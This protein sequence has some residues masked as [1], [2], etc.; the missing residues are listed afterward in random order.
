LLYF[1][2]LILEELKL[3]KIVDF[4]VSTQSKNTQAVSIDLKFDD[5]LAYA[6]ML[7]KT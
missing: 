4:M 5:L 2:Q 1:V 6:P 7:I 3:A